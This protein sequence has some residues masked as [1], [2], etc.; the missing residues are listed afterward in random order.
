M[1][2]MK[3]KYLDSSDRPCTNVCY[4]LGVF[5]ADR[6]YGDVGAIGELPLADQVGGV[7]IDRH[8]R[9]TVRAGLAKFDHDARIGR[10]RAVLVEDQR[11]DIHFLEQAAVRTPFPTRATTRLPARRYW[12]EPCCGNAP[13]ILAMCVPWIS[14]FT[15]NL[16]NGGSETARSPMISTA[17][18]ARAEGDHRAEHRIAGH[19][20]H[21]F[22][23]IRL[24]DHRF[25]G[26]AVHPRHRG[27]CAARCR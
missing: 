25:D 17:G 19:A 3:R 15:R 5:R 23:A 10:Q 12:Q 18:A 22:A 8:V 27:G 9:I 24:D 21:Q 20:Y 7:G 13:S 11:V 1:L 14:S 26:D 2:F 6:A 16:F 4:Q